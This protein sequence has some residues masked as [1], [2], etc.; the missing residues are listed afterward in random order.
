MKAPAAAARRV[1]VLRQTPAKP[2]K[3]QPCN[4]CGF[5][6]AAEPCALAR[7][8]L[9]C[10][11]GPCLAL[12]HDGGRTYC[13]LVRRPARYLTVTGEDLPATAFSA[14]FAGLLRL[15]AGCDSEDGL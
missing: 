15:G 12:E 11:E 14:L 1:I 8:L 3:G 2:P 13:G 10:T 6:C 7:E 5:C 4:G 9:D